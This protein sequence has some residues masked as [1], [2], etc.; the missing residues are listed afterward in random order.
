MPQMTQTL[1]LL[2]LTSGVVLPGMVFTMALET[3]EARVAAEAAGSA[4][5]RLVLVP[6]I[7]G[8]YATV[9]VVAEIVER[10]ELPGGPLAMV[11]RGLER[12][13]IGT[14]VPGTGQALWV[15]VEPIGEAPVTESATEL[16]REYRAVLENI[17]LSRG[18]RQIAER[19]REVTEP[20]QV[21]DLAGYSADLS[22][23]QKVQVLE[24]IDVEA[25]LRLVLGWA[26]ETLADLTL[27]QQIKSNVEEGMEKTQREF[28]LRR[29]LEAI[30]KELGELDGTAD[31][32]TP[33][34][35]RSVIANREL[36]EAVRTAV[37]RELTKLER[38]S[39][40]SPEQGW[41]RTWIDTVLEIPWG[42]TSEDRL[43]VNAA[44][45]VLDQDHDGLVDVK[46]RILEHLAVRALQA[47]RG[48]A[49]LS[50]RGAGATLALVGPPG[51]GKTSLGESVARALGRKFVRVSLG[52]VHDEA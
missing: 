29:Q 44:V 34:H 39:E 13:I 15:Q 42:V 27:R 6:R 8:R 14:G 20:S 38:M 9:G 7:E 28:L 47:E 46:E 51:V 40:Q 17:L 23:A 2:P 52:G 41:V 11:V 21:A 45:R 30:R 25:R 43:D 35:Y 33:E 24:T 31:D 36:P 26:R 4:G 3:E 10:G 48:L 22:L 18:A 1:P 12:A 37:E 19:L 50:G 32:G 16:A 5:G 49:P